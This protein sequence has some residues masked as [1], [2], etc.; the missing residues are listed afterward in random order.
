VVCGIRH[1]HPAPGEQASALGALQMAKR[2]A[3]AR[4]R[5]H[6]E[7]GENV[8]LGRTSATCPAV[9]RDNVSLH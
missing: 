1:F 6:C 5:T 8:M 2:L 3:E 9:G 7:M 4:G